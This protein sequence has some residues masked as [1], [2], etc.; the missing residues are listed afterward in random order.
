MLTLTHSGEENL[1]KVK[2]LV[3]FVKKRF[4]TTKSRLTNAPSLSKIQ[5]IFLRL[6]ILSSY[7]RIIPSRPV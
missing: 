1:V 5:G 7:T 3:E 4:A 6:G 2:S